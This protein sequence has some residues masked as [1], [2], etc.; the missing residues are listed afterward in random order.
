MSDKSDEKQKWIRIRY[1]SL[2]DSYLF[3]PLHDQR[4]AADFSHNI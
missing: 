2:K 4:K 3:M 1:I